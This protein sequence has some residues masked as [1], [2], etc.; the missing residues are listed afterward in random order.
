MTLKRRKK[1]SV[2][3][4]A[5]QWVGIGWRKQE[6]DR[7]PHSSA[8]ECLLTVSYVIHCLIL[9][10]HEEEDDHDGD[11]GDDDDEAANEQR[12]KKRQK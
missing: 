3:M 9:H 2:S 7:K 11:D 6:P 4:M 8:D 1:K 10:C 12:C 5:D